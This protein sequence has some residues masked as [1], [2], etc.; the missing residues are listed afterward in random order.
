[1]YESEI[2]SVVNISV[3]W[4]IACSIVETSSSRRNLNHF[5]WNKAIMTILLDVDLM[6]IIILKLGPE[7]FSGIY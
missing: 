3:H 2:K 6:G 5:S 4:V 7:C 1:M